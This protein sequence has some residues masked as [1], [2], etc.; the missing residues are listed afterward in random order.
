V[1]QVEIRSSYFPLVYSLF[2]LIDCLGGTAVQAVS[3]DLPL[4][5]FSFLFPFSCQED[6]LTLAATSLATPAEPLCYNDIP[7]GNLSKAPLPNSVAG[8]NLMLLNLEDFILG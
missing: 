3:T 5:R 6:A 7:E 4:S 8:G 1:H 2:S